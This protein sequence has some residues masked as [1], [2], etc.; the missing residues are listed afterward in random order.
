MP[1]SQTNQQIGLGGMTQIKVLYLSQTCQ[2][3]GP[4]GIAQIKVL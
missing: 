4:G 2:Q 3:I 1:L